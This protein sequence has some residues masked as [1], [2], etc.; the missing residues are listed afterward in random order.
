MHRSN[1]IITRAARVRFQVAVKQRYAATGLWATDSVARVIEART[2]VPCAAHTATQ[3]RYERVPGRFMPVC[4]K[5]P[6]YVGAPA[7]D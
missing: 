7:E 5:F 3:W 1:I 6:V 2:G 4:Q